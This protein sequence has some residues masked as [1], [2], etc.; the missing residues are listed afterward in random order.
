MALSQVF[1]RSYFLASLEE[2]CVSILGLSTKITAS[3]GLPI[4]MEGQSNNAV[5]YIILFFNE[6]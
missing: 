6:L 1:S 5:N 2:S 3:N 4:I